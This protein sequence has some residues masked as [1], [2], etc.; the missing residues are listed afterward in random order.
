MAFEVAETEELIKSLIKQG[1][2]VNQPTTTKLDKME[3]TDCRTQRYCSVEQKIY[4]LAQ[5]INK[6]AS[7]E[8]M[9]Y[10]IEEKN[11]D[12]AQAEKAVYITPKSQLRGFLP[13]DLIA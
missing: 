10:M 1:A 13:S 9:T 12:V 5:A 11:A 4:P 2:N 3:Y 6:N 8:M 7:E